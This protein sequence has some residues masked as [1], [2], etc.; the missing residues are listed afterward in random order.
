MNRSVCGIV[1]GVCLVFGSVM[2]PGTVAAQEAASDQAAAAETSLRRAWGPLAELV[3]H[4]WMLVYPSRAISGPG[5]PV[6]FAWQVPGTVIVSH[7]GGEETVYRLSTD[8]SIHYVTTPTPTPTDDTGE[9]VFHVIDPTTMAQSSGPARR[10]RKVLRSQPN[11]QVMIWEYPSTSPEEPRSILAYVRA[12]GSTGLDMAPQNGN[13]LRNPAAWGPFAALANARVTLWG[14]RAPIVSADGD[15]MHF[16]RVPGGTGKPYPE[17]T[18]RLAP[19]G[20]FMMRIFSTTSAGEERGYFREGILRGD[21]IEWR[22]PGK[23]TL[24]SAWQMERTRLGNLYMKTADWTSPS[25]WMDWLV[26]PTYYEPGVVDEAL[27]RL[28]AYDKTIARLV[29]SQRAANIE[30]ANAGPYNKFA[31]AA[32]AVLDAGMAVHQAT[33]PPPHYGVS[34]AASASRGASTES[35]GSAP[36]GQSDAPAS[37]VTILL[38]KGFQVPITPG[39]TSNEG[40]FAMVRLGPVTT[41]PVKRAGQAKAAAA[42]AEQQFLAAC[43]TLG[44]LG[45]GGFADEWYIDAKAESAYA[46]MRGNRWM[47]EVSAQ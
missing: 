34:P 31:Q 26:K 4:D 36:A 22:Q 1:L 25:D 11:G 38:W 33:V 44:E 5:R 14:M 9:P 19:D 37:P 12:D 20:T 47:H 2:V 27:A 7:M 13:P 28:E 6:S 32:N 35:E 10:G 15:A 17:F 3:G 46:R 45:S 21:T 41:D 24:D 39:A 16:V 23:D 8:G 40:C 43:R 29:A 18:V 42:S 30:K